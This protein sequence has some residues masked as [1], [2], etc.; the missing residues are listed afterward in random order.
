MTALPALPAKGSFS[1]HETFTFRYPWLKKGVDALRTNPGIFQAENAIV[2]LGVGKNM[3]NSIR[4]WG[5]ATGVLEEK[6]VPGERRTVLMPSDFGS[7]LLS[8]DGWDPYLEDDATLF[9]LHSRLVTNPTRATTWYFVFHLLREPEFTRDTLRHDLKR[10]AETNGW[11]KASE[12]TLVSDISCFVRTYVP[13]K[14]GITSTLE[15]TLD[16]PLTSL[17]LLLSTD[18][19]GE[20]FRFNTRSKPALPPAIFAAALTEYWNTHRDTQNTLSLRDIVHEPGSPGKTFRV[21]EDTTMIYLEA[22]SEVTA[23]ALSFEDTALIRQVR[24]HAPMEATAILERYYDRTNR[25]AQ[26]PR[27]ADLAPEHEQELAHA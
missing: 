7:R 14:R 6:S 8:D 27:Y 17:G 5:L 24:R 10:V 23:G 22:L 25:A 4:Y 26:T 3:V 16:C 21:D 9:L 12:K 20:R 13:V 2:E 15:D 1:G 11:D 19:K 18:G